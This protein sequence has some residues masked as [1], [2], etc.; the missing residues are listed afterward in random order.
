MSIRRVRALYANL[1]EIECKGFCHQSCGPVPATRAE[2]KAIEDRAGKPF[3]PRSDGYC[4]MLDGGRCTVYEDRPLMCRL[5]GL[6]EKMKCPWGCV[7]ER[8]VSNSESR[9]LLAASQRAGGGYDMGRLLEMLDQVK[10]EA[11][12]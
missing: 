2:V 11:S 12:R 8:W 10:A 9:V 3:G 7:P 4:S 5:W 6:V 1:P